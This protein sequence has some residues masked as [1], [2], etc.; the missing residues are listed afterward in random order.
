M[1]PT[2][3]N[4]LVHSPLTQLELARLHRDEGPVGTGRNPTNSTPKSRTSKYVAIL[5]QY[6][7]RVHTPA[8]ANKYK[9]SPW[10][11]GANMMAEVYT[12]V[13]LQVN[14]HASFPHPEP[15]GFHVT[16]MI[17]RGGSDAGCSHK[18]LHKQDSLQVNINKQ[19]CNF[20]K[21]HCELCTELIT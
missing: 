19:R 5:L 21:K 13:Q 11:T 4:Q 17:V 18:W 6:C 12:F 9:E 15:S 1:R 7:S 10:Q 8:P 3:I 20:P 14:A 2:K 16:S